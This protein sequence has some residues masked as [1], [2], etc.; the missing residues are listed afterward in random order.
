MEQADKHEDE[1]EERTDGSPAANDGQTLDEAARGIGLRR[2]SAY[3]PSNERESAEQSRKRSQRERMRRQR[4]EETAQG[5][6]QVN[7]PKV[8]VELVERVQAAANDVIQG[9][10]R[11]PVETPKP[12]S[13]LVSTPGT[14][15]TLVIVGAA[16]LGL[17]VGL[18]VAL[19]L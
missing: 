17:A 11:P 15:S 19:L 6:R 3:I 18:C 14:S 7:I 9:K 1:A 12:A 8:P 16:L 4:A 5:F 2:V 10:T 13:S